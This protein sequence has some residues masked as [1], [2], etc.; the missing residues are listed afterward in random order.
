MCN[1]SGD[2]NKDLHIS[3]DNKGCL[4]SYICTI[5]ALMVKYHSSSLMGIKQ[6]DWFYDLKSNLQPFGELLRKSK[7]VVGQ[8]KAYTHVTHKTK[9]WYSRRTFKHFRVGIWDSC[10]MTQ[11]KIKCLAGKLWHL[12]QPWF[13]FFLI[14]KIF[15]AN[16]SP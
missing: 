4:F 15:V 13:F 9:T 14:S 7:Y 6:R 3:S 2:L 10:V 5:I 11:Y 1:Y 16:K 8:D 12:A